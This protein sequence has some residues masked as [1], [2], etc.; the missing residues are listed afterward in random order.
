MPL[1]YKIL[2]SIVVVLL[3][4]L[5][6]WLEAGGAQ[7]ELAWIVGGIAAV[8]LF[9]LWVFPEAAGGKPERSRAE[10]PKKKA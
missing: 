8:M 6:A 2:L 1:P 5:I 3:A 7:P 10:S 9:G 4:G